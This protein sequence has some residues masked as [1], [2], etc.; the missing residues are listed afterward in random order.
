MNETKTE[1]N[2]FDHST[3]FLFFLF[4]DSKS[5]GTSVTGYN[6]ISCMFKLKDS[7]QIMCKRLA[8]YAQHP[9]KLKNIY[10]HM[11]EVINRIDSHAL[12]L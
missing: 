1:F 11:K 7:A 8:Y 4:W 3:N 5:C 6:Q 10:D 9:E 2:R 12:L